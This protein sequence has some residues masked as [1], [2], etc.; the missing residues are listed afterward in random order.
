MLFNNPLVPLE[1]LFSIYCVNCLVSTKN[2]IL[3]E[4]LRVL[5]SKNY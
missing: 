3:G 2:A 4:G 5:L 1:G